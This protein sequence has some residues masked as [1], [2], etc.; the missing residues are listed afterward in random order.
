[1]RSSP[2][3]VTSSHTA[4]NRPVNYNKQR[5]HKVGHFACCNNKLGL[6]PVPRR[7]KQVSANPT[8]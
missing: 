6:E 7:G 1:M 4:I 8:L 3:H 5:L 2:P